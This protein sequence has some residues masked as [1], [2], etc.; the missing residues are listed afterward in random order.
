M[1]YSGPV[2]CKCAA[3]GGPVYFERGPVD[4]KR[5][6][7]YFKRSAKHGPVYFKGSDKRSES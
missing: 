1:H 6:P 2:Y 5:G 4:C 3:K 7:V